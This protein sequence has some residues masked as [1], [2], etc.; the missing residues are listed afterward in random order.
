MNFQK[1]C[2]KYFKTI[3][4]PPFDSKIPLP[5]LVEHQYVHHLFTWYKYNFNNLLKHIHRSIQ[6]PFPT[7]QMNFF[8]LF[9][10]DLELG[11]QYFIF[12][13][14]SSFVYLF[15]LFQQITRNRELFNKNFRMRLQIILMIDY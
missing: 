9:I 1:N 2:L 6:L 5:K 15:L 7:Q 8:K 11:I 4:F 3:F 12:L 14:Q 10:N 13:V